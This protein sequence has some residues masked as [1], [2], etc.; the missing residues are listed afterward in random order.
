MYGREVAT[1]RLTCWFGGSAYHYSGTENL[2]H[3]WLPELDALRARLETATTAKFNSCL[4]NL[5]RDGADSVSWHSDDEP[6]LGFQPTI[7]SLSLGSTRDFKLRHQTSRAVST[8][9]L[10]HGDLLV[11]RGNS[12]E[13]WR[14][15]IP[16]R[17]H[18]GPRI[19]LTFRWYEIGS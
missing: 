7:A 15:S 2:A 6:E 9:S 1:P 12:Q 18:A 14:H 11:M 4:A 19:N 5:Y 13:A 17:A 3:T 8:V 10:A 16:K